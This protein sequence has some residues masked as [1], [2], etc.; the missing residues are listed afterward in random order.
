MD[1]N[2]EKVEVK[3]E[4]ELGCEDLPLPKSA[5]KYASGIDLYSAQNEV[6]EIEPGERKLIST[7]IKI[8]LPP[9]Y[10]AQVRPRSGLAIS[11]GI[12]VLNS[13][14][15]IDA[16]YRGVIKVILINHG[17]EKFYVNRGDRVAQL[18]IQKVIQPLLIEIKKLDNT[19]RG[20]GGFGH[21]G[22][23]VIE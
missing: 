21:T 13:P 23:K 9:G 19:R 22:I 12:T 18:V 11:Y 2:I 5:S 7:G 15:T 1:N 16:D 4:R 14:G 20:E 6:I 8:A 17:K 3:I 10:E